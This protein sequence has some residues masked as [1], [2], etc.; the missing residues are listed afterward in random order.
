MLSWN[1]FYHQSTIGECECLRG[2][3]TV[4]IV[5]HCHKLKSSICTICLN[6]I[7][8]KI[9]PNFSKRIVVTCKQTN[10][11]FSKQELLF[12]WRKA[13][14][15]EAGFW[16]QGL[17]YSVYEWKCVGHSRQI[18]LIIIEPWIRVMSDPYPDMSTFWLQFSFVNNTNIRKWHTFK[19]V[20]CLVKRFRYQQTLF[21]SSKFRQ[22]ALY[23]CWCM[24]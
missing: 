6:S 17:I 16:A 13:R 8:N 21:F 15:T 11:D 14:K 20:N 7:I 18:E 24:G 23:G 4:M 12:F 22:A 3:S 5:P 9:I 19:S 2:L 10:I 1:V